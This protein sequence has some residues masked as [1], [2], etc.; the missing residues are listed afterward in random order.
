MYPELPDPLTSGDLQQLFSPS[1]DERRWAPTVARTPASQVA[2]LVHLKIFQ[3]IGRFMRAADVP[4]VAIEY[5]ARRLGVTS[6]APLIF[7]DRTIYRHCP[8]ILKCLEVVSWGAEARTL[9]D[10]TM[11]KAARARTDPADIINSAIDALIRHGFELPALATLRRLAGTAHSNVNAAQWKEVCGC[12]SSAQSAVLETLLVVDSKT[13]KSPFANLCKSPGRASRKNLNELIDRYQWLQGLPTPATALQSIADAKILQWANE[14]RRLNALELREYITPRRH[15]LLMAVIHDARGQVLD[16]LT[17]ML[18]RLTRKIEWKSEQR[19]AE[20]YQNRRNKTDSLIRAFHDSLIVHGLEADAVQKVARVES[21]FIAQGGREALAQSCKEHLQ[22]EKQNWRPFAR[23]VFVP[24]RSALIRLAEI[25]PLQG[26]AAADGLLRLVESQTSEPPHSDHLTIDGA[27]PNTLP[28]EWRDLV[29]DHASDKLVFNRRQLEVVVMLELATAIKA[30]EIFV[31]GSLSFDRFWDSLPSEAADP[32]AVAAYATAR[33]WEDGADGLVRAVKNA[34]ELKARFLDNAV[35]GGQQAYLR[36]GKHGRPVVSRLRAVGTQESA[37]DLESQMMAYMPERAVL[38]A[39]SNTEHWAQWGRHFGL[40]SRLGP[41]IKDAS[42][43]YVL[44]TFAY[45]CGLGPTEAARHLGGTVSADQLAFADRRHV[46]IEDLRAA[47]ADLINLYAQF[48]LPQQWGTGESVAADG[49]HFETYEDNL[50]AEHHIRYGKTGGIAYRHVADNYIALFSRFIACGT[51]EATYILDALLQNLADVKPSRV[52]ADT[53]GQSA[54]VFGLAYLLGIELMPRIRRWQSLT[55]YRSDNTNRYARINSLFSDTVNWAQIHEHYRQ[56]TQLA[57]AIQSGTLAPSAVLAKVNSYSTR[58]RFA[59]ALKELG[60]AVRT[61]YLL[62][63]VMDES[64][65]R[66]VHKGTTKI[67]RHHK[68]AKH[69]AFGAGGHLRSN[70]PADQEKAIVYNELVTN[71]V[72]LQTVVDQTQALHTLKSKGISIR[73]SDLAFLSP[74]ATSK[75]KRFG[76]Y[77]TDLKPEAMPV[78][79][80]LPL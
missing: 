16:E 40:P 13:Q 10:A 77:P 43:R 69:L 21:V 17:Q 42:H 54:A 74:Y 23:A 8:T 51:Y 1:F 62:E 12:I 32:G 26:T 28:R 63:W 5:V 39:I 37:T 24:L 65:R 20:W 9:A 56:F 29:H 59:M 36:R 68:F 19:L 61:T 30:G 70:N 35:G 33:G 75:L 15:T 25:L 64:L 79:T 45:G 7:A 72:A 38:E 55:L 44:T 18:L 78:R 80:T 71:A 58:N 50:L 31:T 2:L 4:L 53:H 49:T 11:F 66:T 48:E 34:L 41:K 67:E 3:T 47:S 14:A 73:A 22:H 6:P 27:A 76:D 52:H 46:D 57:L 60:N